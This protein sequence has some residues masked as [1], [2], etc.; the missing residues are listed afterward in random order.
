VL[1]G[2]LDGAKI[3]SFKGSSNAPES[4]Y[5]KAMNSWFVRVN[6]KAYR[7]IRQLLGNNA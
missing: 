1:L 6:T 3:Y 4:F 5:V 7:F 2:Y